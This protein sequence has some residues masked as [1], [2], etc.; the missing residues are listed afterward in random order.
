MFRIFMKK[1]DT[2]NKTEEF[3]KVIEKN[4]N[5]AIVPHYNP[6]PDALGSSFGLHYLLSKFFNKK[7][8][9]YFGG[10]IGRAENKMMIDV[11]D[12][13]VVNVKEQKLPKKS[14]ILMDTQPGTGNNPLDKTTIPLM[15]FDHHPFHKSSL[16]ADFHDIRL[17]YG[18]TSTIIYNYLRDFK[19]KPLVNIATALYYGIQTDV[20]GEGRKANKVD[21]TALE[22]LSKHINRE[23]LYTIENPKLPFDYYIHVNK[24]MENSVI[25]NDFVISSLGEI[26]NPDYIGEIADF[27]IRFNKAYLVLVMGIYKDSILL[28]FRSQKKKIDAGLILR[29]IIKNMGEAGGHVSNAGGRILLENSEDIP[30]ISKK[31]IE[32]SLNILQG[33]ITTGIPFLSLSDYLNIK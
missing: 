12:I 33:K 28:S 29:K 21:F 15:I 24:G 1:K 32:N 6:D 20:V 9:I 27:L 8:T 14:I 4:D 3:I 7:A 5:F 10:I 30:K 23:K 2:D 19:I 16:A 31:L 26:K 17:N 11:L 22:L 18:S 25:Y 13:P